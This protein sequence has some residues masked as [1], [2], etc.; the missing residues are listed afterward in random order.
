MSTLSEIRSLNFNGGLSHI[1]IITGEKVEIY[2][3]L[4]QLVFDWDDKRVDDWLNTLDDG[5]AQEFPSFMNG[6][7]PSLTLTDVTKSEVYPGSA[8][9]HFRDETFVFVESTI[10]ELRLLEGDTFVKFVSIVGNSAVP[11][12]H[13][14]GEKYTYILSYDEKSA[15]PN[16]LFNEKEDVYYT[17]DDHQNQRIPLYVNKLLENEYDPDNQDGDN[18]SD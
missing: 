3:C 12:S 7:E 4:N 18:D 9:F 15:F 17:I 8:L 14:V 6:V 2:H 16:E 5:V 1:L 11:Y 10:M 13:I